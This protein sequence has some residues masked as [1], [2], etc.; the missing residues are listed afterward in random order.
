MP[1]YGY[2]AYGY[3]F[4]AMG[5]QVSQYG[6]RL[7]KLLFLYWQLPQFQLAFIIYKG[8][9]YTEISPNNARRYTEISPNNSRRYT[10]ISFL[11]NKQN[12]RSNLI[13][14][15]LSQLKIYFKKI[16][17]FKINLVKAKRTVRSI[18]RIF[19]CYICCFFY[20]NLKNRQLNLTQTL[21][22]KLQP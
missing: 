8:R 16:Y 9:R 18:N 15:Y 17:D 3:G 11:K 12:F 4:E 1:N 20:F 2:G 6:M 7:S 21:K 5:I 22:L 19:G 14:M 10:E 13:Y